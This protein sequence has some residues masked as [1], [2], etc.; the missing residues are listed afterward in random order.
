MHL[1]KGY[2]QD[3]KLYAMS[4]LEAFAENKQWLVI[5]KQEML[6]IL[7][8]SGE[9]LGDLERFIRGFEK[10]SIRKQVHV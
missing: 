9:Y 7:R 1:L 2:P 3:V 4:V 10:G 5:M 8:D 6:N